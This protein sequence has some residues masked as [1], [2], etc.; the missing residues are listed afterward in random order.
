MAAD[1]KDDLLAL[2][3]EKVAMFSQPHTA[4]GEEKMLLERLGKIRMS[5][6]IMPREQVT[7]EYM[8]NLLHTTPELTVTAP[9]KAVSPQNSG[10]ASRKKKNTVETCDSCGEMLIGTTCTKCGKQ[11]KEPAQRSKGKSK[12]SMASDIE[13][14]P[15]DLDTLL[16]K[17]PA[18]PEVSGKKDALVAALT[19]LRC[20]LKRGE[21]ISISMMRKAFQKVGLKAHYVWCCRMR[22]EITN[23]RPTDFTPEQRQLFANYYFRA[24]EPFSKLISSS[25]TSESKKMTNKWCKQAIFKTILNSSLK[26]RQGHSDFL[27]SLSLQN[28]GTETKHCEIWNGMCQKYG[29]DFE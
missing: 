2:I 24:L 12:D 28:Q 13:A 4:D 29:W 9:G 16:A 7:K 22:Y 25:T 15:R 14:F 10:K 27:D 6:V 5:V 11:I 21:T 3:D 8:D 23:Y 1:K 26:L 18:P 19:E 20:N 17:L